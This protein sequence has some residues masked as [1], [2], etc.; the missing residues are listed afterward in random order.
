MVLGVEQRVQA[1]AKTWGYSSPVNLKNL[2]PEV[3]VLA[4]QTCVQRAIYTCLSWV[5][6]VK[7]GVGTGPRLD[8]T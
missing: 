3:R 1:V 8:E 6:T 7:M 4:S 5:S 2:R